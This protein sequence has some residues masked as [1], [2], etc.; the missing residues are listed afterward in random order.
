MKLL[1]V[2]TSAKLANVFVTEDGKLLAE[3]F[4]GG[5]KTHASML[6]PVIDGALKDAGLGIKD[7][8][9]IGVVNGPGSYTGL[10]IAVACAKML[11]YG[12]GKPLVTVNTL[13]FLALSAA[14]KI[15]EKG[16]GEGSRILAMLDAR[17]TLC[18]YALYEIKAGGELVNITGVKS[19]YA[20][21]IA[22]YVKTAGYPENKLYLCGDGAASNRE[23]LADSFREALFTEA[24][25]TTGNYIGASKAVS[26]KLAEGEMT[27]FA[28]EKAAADYYKEVHITLRSAEK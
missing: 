21:D 13:D 8:D 20:E 19:D 6:L 4:D 22:K 23:L 10:R 11:A 16:V 1:F 14:A 12:A 18:F 25:D 26:L 28:P 9:V 17:N 24:P 2:D 7:V 27:D 5:E 3:G 15:N